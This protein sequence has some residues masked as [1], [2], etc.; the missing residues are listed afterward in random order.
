MLPN[1]YS[2]IPV[3]VVRVKT[4]VNR[5]FD[6]ACVLMRITINKLSFVPKRFVSSVVNAF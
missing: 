6:P 4:H 5:L 1:F 3:D 2:I